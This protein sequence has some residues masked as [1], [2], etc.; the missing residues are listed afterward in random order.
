MTDKATFNCQQQSMQLVVRFDNL[1]SVL[2]LPFSVAEES[3][4]HQQNRLLSLWATRTGW[5]LRYLR[6]SSWDLPFV[7]INSRSSILGGKGGFGTLLKGQSRQAGAKLTT[8]FGACRDLQG[9]RLRHVNDEIKLRKWREMKRREQAG[10]KVPDDELWKTPSGIYNWHLLTP[11]W[12]DISKKATYGIKRQF[13][14]LDK[15]A[16]KVALKKQEQE[17]AYQNSMT[18]YLEQATTAT[19]SIQKS[20]PDA[21]QQG[22]AAAAA[23]AGSNKRKHPDTNPLLENAEP[24]SLLELSGEWVVEAEAGNPESMS[25]SGLQL[26]SKSEFGT[27]VLVLDHVAADKIFTIYY[28]VTLVTGGLAQ[29]GWSSLMGDT[30]FAPNNELGDGVGDD[31]ASFAVDGSRKLKFHAGREEKYPLVWKQGDRLGCWMNTKDSTIGFSVNGVDFG[32]AFRFDKEKIEF[33]PAFSCNQGQILQL[34][35]TK[36]DCKYF[37]GDDTVAVGDLMMTTAIPPEG[38]QRRPNENQKAKAESVVVSSQ[39]A[40]TPTTNVDPTAP[41]KK[42]AIEPQPLDLNPFHSAK[43]LEELGL[44]RLKSALMALRV[45]CGGTLAERAARLFSL[46]GLDRNDYPKKVRAKGSEIRDAERGLSSTKDWEIA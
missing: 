1:S 26:Q 38:I 24:N 6:I 31:A 16:Q 22:L 21:I 36:A 43:E 40:P 13:Q 9:R 42:E 15:A 33:V 5:P 19:E 8:D 37:P 11:T 3:A 29:I 27:A 45:K 20:I 44:D 18:H 12:A 35:T 28:E 46:K 30:P 2:C 34:H 41:A 7:T 39:A 17:V 23:V 4:Q 32:E 14:Q 10:E 25:S